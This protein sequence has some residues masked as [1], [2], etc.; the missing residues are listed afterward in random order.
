V[1]PEKTGNRAIW[2]RFTGRR[3]STQ[4]R[5]G[6]PLYLPNM[7]AAAQQVA[8]EPFQKLRTRTLLTVKLSLQ[9]RQV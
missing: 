9:S 5:P 1:Q 4:Q 6:Q 3:R 2:F 8:E 7:I